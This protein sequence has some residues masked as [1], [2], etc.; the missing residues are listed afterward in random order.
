MAVVQA[1]EDYATFDIGWVVS[2]TLC[3]SIALCSNTDRQA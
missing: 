2:M 1:S 3:D